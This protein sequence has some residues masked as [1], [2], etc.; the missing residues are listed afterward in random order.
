MTSSAVTTS[1]SPMTTSHRVRRRASGSSASAPAAKPAQAPQ[2]RQGHVDAEETVGTI[3]AVVEPSWRRLGYRWARAEAHLKQS[4]RGGGR[5]DQA[6]RPQEPVRRLPTVEE[7][8]GDVEGEDQQ[9]AFG[10]GEARAGMAGD[11]G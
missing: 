4:D 1:A 6:Q 5:D 2:P 3:A 11:E 8:R 7:I 9:Q 10:R